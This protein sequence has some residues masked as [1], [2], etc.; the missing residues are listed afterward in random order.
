M[1]RD[2]ICVLGGETPE[3]N[4]PGRSRHKGKRDLLDVVVDD[5]ALVEELDA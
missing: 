2:H 3:E 4:K 5:A 1:F